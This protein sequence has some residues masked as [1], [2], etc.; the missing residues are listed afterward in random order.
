MQRILYILF[1]LASFVILALPTTYEAA[2]LIQQ[3]VNVL[4]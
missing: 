2:R 3:G 4:P 1:G